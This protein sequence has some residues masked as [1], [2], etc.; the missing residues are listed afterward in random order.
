M[1]DTTDRRSYEDALPDIIELSDQG[2]ILLPADSAENTTQA[3]D[4]FRRYAREVWGWEKPVTNAGIDGPHTYVLF[5]PYVASPDDYVEAA[6]AMLRGERVVGDM[7]DAIRS[8]AETMAQESS[9]PGGWRRSMFV[10]P[11][12]PS[13]RFWS[14]RYGFV[15]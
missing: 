9:D 7:D 4:H 5:P 11:D 10:P 12:M 13:G 14:I 8:L 6:T 1:T 2:G 15:Q 3:M